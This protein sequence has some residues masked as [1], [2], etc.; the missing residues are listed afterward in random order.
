A[1]SC[2]IS[3]FSHG[4]TS[5]PAVNTL[6][7]VASIAAFT[8]SRGASFATVKTKAR[9]EVRFMS[10][11]KSQANN[12]L[13]AGC[14][15]AALGVVVVAPAAA[16]WH[17]LVAAGRD[18]FGLAGGWEY[19]VPLSLDGAARYAAALSIRAILSA[20]SAV[21]ARLLTARYALAAS[22]L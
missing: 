21:G 1:C 11:Q 16:S 22:G 18:L 14:S 15:M 3:P 6:T 12:R 20:D 4:S 10:D 8:Y 2:L 17:G 5:V 19:V 9:L 7:S 13:R